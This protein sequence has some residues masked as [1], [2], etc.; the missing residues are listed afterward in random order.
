MQL[1]FV[2]NNK[3]IKY[4][5]GRIEL[6]RKFPNVSFVEPLEQNDLLPFGVVV[7]RATPQPQFDYKTQKL[8]EGDPSLSESGWE[9]SWQVTPLSEEER[10]KIDNNKA[11]SVREQ[12]NRLL[13][14]TDWTQLADSTANA[15]D[16]AT[17]RQALRDLPSTDGFPHNV[18]WP[19]QPS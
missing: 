7:V 9:Q 17:Y 18:T 14:N 4:P 16:W 1:A 13:T 10:A 6:K 3:I 8:E 12:R 15:A 19:T 2:D 11:V 5:I